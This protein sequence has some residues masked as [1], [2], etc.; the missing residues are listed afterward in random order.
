MA[1][2]TTTLSTP[3][4]K[5]ATVSPCF[6]ASAAYGSP[7]ASEVGILRTV[8]DRYLAPTAPGRAFIKLYYELGP[9][10]AEPVREQPWLASTVR[11]LLTPVVRLF[12]W[13]VDE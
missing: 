13:W 9:S 11:F 2:S 6:I 10:L 8:R 5:F 7:L 1:T 3:E 4:R 12:A